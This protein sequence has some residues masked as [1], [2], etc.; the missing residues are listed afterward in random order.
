MA[1]GNIFQACC[2]GTAPTKKSLTIAMKVAVCAA[3]S[4][5]AE[6][7]SLDPKAN[8]AAAEILKQPVQDT[9]KSLL[10]SINMTLLLRLRSPL[11]TQTMR[12]RSEV[13]QLL[14][15]HVQDSCLP[16]GTL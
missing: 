15:S 10:G 12:S 13:L 2:I 14:S 3:G 11:S 5:T 8:P 9:E 4:L 7:L 16:L 6:H 1:L